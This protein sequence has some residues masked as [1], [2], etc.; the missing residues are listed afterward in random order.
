MKCQLG[1]ENPVSR[2]GTTNCDECGWN[3]D[4]NRQRREEIHRL[5]A[6][7]ELRLWGKTQ[8]P[9]TKG[10]CSMSFEHVFDRKS[11][12]EAVAAA[13]EDAGWE[14]HWQRGLENPDRYYLTAYK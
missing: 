12:C 3:V 4:I 13:L 9:I 10:A 2:C 6:R 11:E 7:H 1:R 5:A 8:E 14:V